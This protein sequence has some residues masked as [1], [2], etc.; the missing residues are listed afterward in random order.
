[1]HFKQ[2]VFVFRRNLYLLGSL[3]LVALI[4]LAL[5]Q[6]HANES[7]G[8]V[9]LFMTMWGLPVALYVAT[10]NPYKLRTARVLDADATG[11]SL[12]DK[13]VIERSKIVAGY[14]Q[15]SLRIVCFNLRA[16]GDFQVEVADVASA[17]ELLSVLGLDAGNATATFTTSSFLSATRTGPFPRWAVIAFV[18]FF[19]G[20]FPPLYPIA[21]VL[22]PVLGVF[23]LWP[24][25]VTVGPDGV[26][27]TWLGLRRFYPFSRI[28][29]VLQRGALS[30]RNVIT[31]ADG[32]EVHLIARENASRDEERHAQHAALRLRVEGA[33]EAYRRRAPEGDPTSLLAAGGRS[34]IEWMR[35]VRA[36]NAVSGGYRQ[37]ALSPEQMWRVVQDPTASPSTRAGAAMALS[38]SLDEAGRDALLRAAEACAHPRVRVALTSLAAGEP[39]DALLHA[40]EPLAEEEANVRMKRLILP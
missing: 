5:M 37:A 22:F 40:L 34:A 26:L 15:P 13:I 2:S 30:T 3:V 9:G 17:N 36:M 6:T 31:L 10:Q 4:G 23:A 27:L 12:D 1:M 33:L 7:L 24:A 21:L 28:R 20:F 29:S 25:H 14:V 16:G 18:L 32:G 39:E 38:P 19:A 11:I 8:L 35:S